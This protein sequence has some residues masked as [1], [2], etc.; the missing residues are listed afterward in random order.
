MPIEIAILKM[1]TFGMPIVLVC[2]IVSIFP[3]TTQMESIFSKVI[4]QH[5]VR[6]ITLYS[7]FDTENKKVRLHSPRAPHHAPRTTRHAR[8]HHHRS[9]AHTHTRARDA[10]THATPAI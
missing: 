8:T 10:R 6:L 2:S 5:N 9:V 4:T 7:A 1:E 3:Q